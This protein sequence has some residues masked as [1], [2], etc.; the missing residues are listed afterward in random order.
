MHCVDDSVQPRR[1]SPFWFDGNVN[2]TRYVAILKQFKAA[3]NRKRLNNMKKQLFIQDGVNS[4]TAR[5]TMA[6]RSE[7]FSPRVISKNAE[8]EWSP[9]SPNLNPLDFFRWSYLKDKAY[10]RNSQT[11]DVIV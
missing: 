5:V 7:M 1:D 11:I 9:Y 10:K 3:L 6:W 8:F 2:S 4:H